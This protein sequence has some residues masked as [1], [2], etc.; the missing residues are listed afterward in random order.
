MLEYKR[1]KSQL[2]ARLEELGKQY[3]Y[4]DVHLRTIDAWWLQVRLPFRP[5]HH[6]AQLTR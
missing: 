3:E 5:R 6:E 4:Y 2:E 1:E